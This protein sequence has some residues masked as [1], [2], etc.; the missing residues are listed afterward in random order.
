MSKRFGGQAAGSKAK[1]QWICDFC[2]TIY[3][4]K[5]KI[6]ER[7]GASNITYFQSK[8]ELKRWLEL[9]Q[10]RDAGVIEGLARQVVFEFHDIGGTLL[11]PDGRVMK[12]VVDFSYVENGEMVYEDSKGVDTDLGYLKRELVRFFYGHE[13][14]LT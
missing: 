14:K 12:H 13:I 11:T 10:L 2:S 4:G 3:A 8:A 6:C 7:C 9:V 5:I 1:R